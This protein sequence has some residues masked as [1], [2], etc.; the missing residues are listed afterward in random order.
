MVKQLGV[1]IAGRQRNRSQAAY[2]A[3]QMAN[4]QWQIVGWVRFCTA[5]AEP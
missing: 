3:A 1:E 2:S 5:A 4:G